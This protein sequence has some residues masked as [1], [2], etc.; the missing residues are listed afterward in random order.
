MLQPDLV[1]FRH[2][3]RD[4]IDV[5]QPVT[6]RPDLAVEVLSRSTEARDR[7]GKMEMYARFGVPEYWIVDP[8]GNTLEIYRLDDRQYTLAS[9]CGEDG[10]ASSST[11][12][13]LAT[14]CGW[15]FADCLKAD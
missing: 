12:A 5:M 13:D 10:R 1:F 4:R 2:E 8:V 7:G 14:A 9:R 11:L 6:V 15:I 3:Q